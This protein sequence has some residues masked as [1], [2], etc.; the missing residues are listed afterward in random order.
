MEKQIADWRKKMASPFTTE[1]EV[2]QL[3]D[4]IERKTKQL[5]ELVANAP[6]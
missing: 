2:E 6:K 1:A 4:Q 5:R 3:R